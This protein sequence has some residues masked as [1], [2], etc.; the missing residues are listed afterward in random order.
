VTTHL[1]EGHPLVKSLTD[2]YN[3]A[4]SVTHWPCLP[5]GRSQLTTCCCC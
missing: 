5:V 1:G 3:N 4:K 2:S